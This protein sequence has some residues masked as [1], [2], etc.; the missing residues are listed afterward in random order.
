MISF[1]RDEECVDE[2][3]CQVSGPKSESI[4][5][6]DQEELGTRLTGELDDG[7][8]AIYSHGVKRELWEMEN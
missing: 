8:A 4:G 5:H 2:S 6:S 7:D 3:T 1:G